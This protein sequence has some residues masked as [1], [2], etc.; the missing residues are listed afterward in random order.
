M[1]AGPTYNSIQKI[2]LSGSY[3]SLDFFNI[4]QTYTDLILVCQGSAATAD[5]NALAF[6]LNNDSGTTYSSTNA[7]GTG[8][9]TPSQR[10]T[11]QSIG[12]AGFAVGWDTTT[13]EQSTQI[14][15]FFNYSNTT[16]NKVIVSRSGASLGSYPGAEIVVTSWRNTSAVNRISVF[17]NTGSFASGSTFNLYGVT[18]A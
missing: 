16:T 14:I 13:A 1:P 6:R 15:H 9:T 11:N 18:A 7:A 17:V 12:Y 5:G 4:P 10:L 8:T 2:S 3:T